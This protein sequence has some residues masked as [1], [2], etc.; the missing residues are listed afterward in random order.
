MDLEAFL[1]SVFQG[2]QVMNAVF[3]FKESLILHWIR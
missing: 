2:S 3:S 1:L